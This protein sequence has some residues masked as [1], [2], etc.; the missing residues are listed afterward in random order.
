MTSSSKARTALITGGSSGIGYAIACEFA[1]RGYRLILVSN[2]EER[3]KDVAEELKTKY[4]I[5]VYSLFM[6]LALIDAA[7]KL[8]EWCCNEQLEVDVLVN[9]AGFFHF[10]EVVETDTA[11]AFNMMS[12]HVSTPA[13]LC[14]FFG[15]EMKQRRNGNII[16]ISSL[17]SYMPYPGI[18]LYSATKRFLKSFSRSLRTEMLD[19]NVNV[20]CICPG[21]VSTNL[22]G[23]SND[24]R[25]LAIK[26]GIMMPPEKLARKIV[27]ATNCRKSVLIPGMI[28]RFFLPFLFIIP[29]GIIL[30]IRRH[31]RFLPPDK[32]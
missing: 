12:L 31:T 10:G 20:S 27:R 11:K 26:S 3:L 32:K 23:L 2:Q 14:T 7:A 17:A 25:K 29:H 24:K 1:S 6:D 28:N 4:N 13:M 5:E 8:Y 16:I 22:Y 19:Y 9:N 30:M 18:A 15:K 21:A